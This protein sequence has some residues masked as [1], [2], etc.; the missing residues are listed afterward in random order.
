VSSQVVRMTF[1]SNSAL[2]PEHSGGRSRHLL[3]HREQS[4]FST[5]WHAVHGLN[6]YIRIHKE[7]IKTAGIS[8]RHKMHQPANPHF[9]E[10][11]T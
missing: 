10:V 5:L 7:L 11:F 2:N 4:K 3:V 8:L 1:T 9:S 6:K